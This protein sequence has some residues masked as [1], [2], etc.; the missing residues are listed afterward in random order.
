VVR[1]VRTLADAGLPPATVVTAPGCHHLV[2]NA[3]AAHP[4]APA[5]RLI[6]NPVPD[7]GQLS[8]LWTALNSLSPDAHAVVVMLVDV[9]FVSVH[10]VRSVVAAYVQTHA[11]I[12]RPADGDRHGH[13][14][15]FDRAVF[16][17]LLEAD[18]AV[19]AKTIVRAHAADILNVP[20][21]DPGAF[22]DVDTPD[23]Y[24]RALGLFP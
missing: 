3:L 11:A 2:V 16:S 7:Q 20:V 23:E 22:F 13:P 19:G 9:P 17:E 4:V 15:I 18:P 5:A 24:E 8:T 14:V 10:T 1:I 21:R 12:V 6:I